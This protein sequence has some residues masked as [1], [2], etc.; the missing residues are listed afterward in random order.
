[1]NEKKAEKILSI[2]IWELEFSDGSKLNRNEWLAS[3]PKGQRMDPNYP[4]KKVSYVRLLPQK[5]GYPP[6][7]VHIPDGALPVVERDQ[8]RLNGVMFFKGVFKIGFSI[9]SMRFMTCIE[10]PKIKIIQRFDTRG[11][12]K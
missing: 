1:M 9:G 11:R 3:A 6:A 2:Y 5:D 4:G 8:H 10:V 12:K 7:E